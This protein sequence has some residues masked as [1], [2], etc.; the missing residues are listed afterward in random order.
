MAI[1][2]ILLFLVTNKLFY[3]TIKNTA[4]KPILAGAGLALSCRVFHVLV[5]A[6]A[7]VRVLPVL[8]VVQQEKGSRSLPK[9]R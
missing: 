8:S 5:F 3:Q 4:A 6:S 2:K 7:L 1:T 9:L